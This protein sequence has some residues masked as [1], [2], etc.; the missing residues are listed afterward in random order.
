[1]N[2]PEVYCQITGK[3]CRRVPTADIGRCDDCTESRLFI[4]EDLQVRGFLLEEVDIVPCAALSS[5]C[6]THVQ[7]ETMLVKI[8]QGN[9]LWG[10]R[11]R[12][13]VE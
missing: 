12:K 13:T 10:Q 9:I 11:N 8:K 3:L 1:M 5:I 7:T 4:D 2:T 6:V